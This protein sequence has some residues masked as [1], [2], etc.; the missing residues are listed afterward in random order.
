MSRMPSTVSP[1]LQDNVR[2]VH[3][4]VGTYCP[5]YLPWTLPL[6]QIKSSTHVDENAKPPTGRISQMVD[7]LTAYSTGRTASSRSFLRTK[8]AIGAYSEG[9]SPSR[10]RRSNNNTR[11]VYCSRHRMLRMLDRRRLHG[12]VS[13][14]RMSALLPLWMQRCDERNLLVP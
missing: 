13:T 4:H 6:S 11:A 12:T 5:G 14:S 10:S 9:N 1:R 2:L 3:G 8:R 7:G